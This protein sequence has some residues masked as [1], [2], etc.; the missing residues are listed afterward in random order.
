MLKNCS[1]YGNNPL[2]MVFNSIANIAGDSYRNAC[3]QSKKLKGD[4]VVEKR[5]TI[6]K[7]LKSDSSIHIT[8]PDKGRGVVV[9]N[10]ADYA[11]KMNDILSDNTKFKLLNVDI[12]THIVKLEDKLNRI[13]RG[14][15]E[16]IGDLIYSDLYASG[17][18]PGYMYGLPKVHKPGN[19]LQP[20]ISSIGAF[21]YRL[22][23]FLVSILKPLT[24]KPVHHY[25][26][27]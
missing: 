12:A 9:L 27:S 13:L 18:K 15:R 25:E 14:I 8:K 1:L 20:I 26:F 16:R 2:N 23:K 19:P 5:M 17:S 21:S 11:D 10:K 24:K 4:K 3:K 6:L 7:D 22:S